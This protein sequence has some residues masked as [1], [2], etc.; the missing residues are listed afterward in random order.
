MVCPCAFAVLRLMLNLLRCGPASSR[1]GALTLASET[2]VV[3]RRWSLGQRVQDVDRPPHIQ[4]FPEPAG[5]RRPRVEVQ[6]VR[7]VRGAERRDGISGHRP[8]RR[9][10]RQRAAVRSEEPER[11]VGPPRDLVALLVDGAVMSA[12]KKREVRE[13]GGAPVGPVAEVMPLAE[14]DAAAR[15]PATPVTMVERP[16]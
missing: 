7:V 1:N 9:H 14:A 4:P 12:A 5:A 8:R 11:A 3:K 15:K 2:G 16:P 13:R 6:A 10:L